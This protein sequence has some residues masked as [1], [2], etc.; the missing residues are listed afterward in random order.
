VE[1]FVVK[2]K[3]ATMEERELEEALFNVDENVEIEYNDF[4]Q[5]M[6]DERGN[7]PD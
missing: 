5:D 2:L 4:E 6:L 7:E 1:Q 3:K